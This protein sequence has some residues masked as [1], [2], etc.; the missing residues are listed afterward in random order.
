MNMLAL[1]IAL[2]PAAQSAELG[3]LFFTPA[4]RTQSGSAQAEAAPTRLDGIVQKHGGHRTVWL[5]GVAQDAPPAA[6]CDR[7]AIS[8]PPHGLQLKVGESAP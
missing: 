2:L 7:Q 1:L 3:R 4:Q 6:A 5:N 8:P